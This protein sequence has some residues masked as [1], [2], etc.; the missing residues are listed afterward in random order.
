[1]L[2]YTDMDTVTEI[3][4]DIV[5]DMDIDNDLDKDM[6]TDTWH[7]KIHRNFPKVC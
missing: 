6:D 3:V 5:I 2:P 1:M 7:V 4:T